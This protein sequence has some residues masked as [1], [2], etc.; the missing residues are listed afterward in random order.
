MPYVNNQTTNLTLP[1]ERF[2]IDLESYIGETF[3]KAIFA[4]DSPNI[5]VVKDWSDIVEGW[6]Y[7]Q[8]ETGPWW[9]S[10]SKVDHDNSNGD[11][12]FVTGRGERWFLKILKIST[13]QDG[14]PGIF[15][16]VGAGVGMQGEDIDFAL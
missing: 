1:Y 8:Y 4:K 10:H 15:D 9:A 16:W 11:I 3:G 13:I 14:V 5:S 6:F 12:V 7:G 2:D